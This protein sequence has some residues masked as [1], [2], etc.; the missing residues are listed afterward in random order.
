MTVGIVRTTEHD[1][2]VVLR[3]HARGRGDPGRE[4]RR[5]IVAAVLDGH[6]R[7]RAIVLFRSGV[8]VSRARGE[9]DER[10]A[11]SD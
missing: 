4:R 3:L 2:R 8:E 10:G 7:D 9:E 11:G 5:R 6:R 1:D